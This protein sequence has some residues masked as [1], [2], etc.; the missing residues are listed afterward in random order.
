[1]IGATALWKHGREGRKETQRI[2]HME[3]CNSMSGTTIPN[4]PLKIPYATKQHIAR[5][6]PTISLLID[7]A[8]KRRVDMGGTPR[9]EDLFE[10][11]DE[12]FSELR[13]LPFEVPDQDPETLRIA[14]EQFKEGTALS[15]ED[16]LNETLAALAS[17]NTR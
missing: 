5:F 4:Q 16:Y 8:L 1:M 9:W 17:S 3:R 15:G 11:I 10:A 7:R 13:A 2:C 14:L 12:V 6:G